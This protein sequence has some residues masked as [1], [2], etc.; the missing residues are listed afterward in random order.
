MSRRIRYTMLAV[1][2]NSNKA[3]TTEEAERLYKDELKR[4]IQ[5]DLA[6][7]DNWRRLIRIEPGFDAI[8]H[9]DLSAIGIERGP[10]R[11]R[12]H[13]HFVVTIQHHGKILWRYTQRAWQQLINEKLRYTRGSNVSIDLMDS[14]S[15]NYTNK[16]AGTTR[17][18]RSIG[19]Q[20]EVTL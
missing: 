15:M 17:Q 7:G 1:T 11:H 10:K 12:I 8:D 2:I 5:T 4:F 16:N 14:R 13:A 9:I 20:D 6:Q 18:L 19:I 3:A